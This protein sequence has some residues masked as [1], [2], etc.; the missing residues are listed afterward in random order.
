MQ[1]VQT[2]LTEQIMHLVV[3]ILFALIGYIGIKLQRIIS[4]HIKDDMLRKT[5]T[6][7]VGAV[8]SMATTMIIDKKET[9]VELATQFCESKGLPCTK[10]EIS[11][12]VE[13]AVLQLKAAGLEQKK[14]E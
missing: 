10:D 4:A 8:E 5:F 13:Y 1:E 7:I 14:T 11:A 2:M 9:A 12:L 6:T 3:S